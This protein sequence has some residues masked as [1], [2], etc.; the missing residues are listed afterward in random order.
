MADKGFDP[1]ECI[2]L[3]NHEQRMQRLISMVFFNWCF[4]LMFFIDAFYWN[5]HD[6]NYF[7]ESIFQ[8]RDSQSTCN[9][10]ECFNEGMNQWILMCTHWKLRMHSIII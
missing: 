8:L 7:C 10:N 6:Y 4:L 1:C 9:D 2:N 3:L 5:L